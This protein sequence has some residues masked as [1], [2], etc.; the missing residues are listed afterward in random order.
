MKDPYLV[1]L[2]IGIGVIFIS[3]IAVYYSH[4]KNSSIRI[5]N[6]R[7]PQKY[8]LPEIKELN[9]Q[10]TCPL[11][12]CIIPPIVFS[13][14]A[15]YENKSYDRALK[16][17]IDF[18]K[19]NP[20]KAENI[21]NSYIN[22]TTKYQIY[23]SKCDEIFKNY[24]KSIGWKYSSDPIPRYL[25][26]NRKDWKKAQKIVSYFKD[27]IIRIPPAFSCKILCSY[28]S[29]A[30]RVSL[31]RYVEFTF[32]QFK[33]HYDDVVSCLKS[34]RNSEVNHNKYYESYSN[35]R[36][37]NNVNSDF[38]YNGNDKFSTNKSGYK[39][40]L[41]KQNKNENNNSNED[42][43]NKIKA[44][45]DMAMSQNVDNLK[46]ILELK[47]KISQLEYENKK[48]KEQYVENNQ[49]K[50]KTNVN[51]I[52]YSQ[53]EKPKDPVVHNEKQEKITS[54]I[55]PFEN[56]K[57]IQDKKQEK[58]NIK[59]LQKGEYDSQFIKCILPE[60]VTATSAIVKIQITQQSTDLEST[61][62]SIYAVS[63]IGELCSNIA[64]IKT[65]KEKEIIDCT[66]RIQAE[67]N[68]TLRLVLSYSKAID[69]VLME[70]PLYN[71]SKFKPLI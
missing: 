64:T 25:F 14:R 66:L 65:E 57:S 15:Q 43:L 44:Q 31:S 40:D 63:Q 19:S 29:P 48:I 59:Q 4:N 60:S 33:N 3:A 35:N 27:T 34:K 8:V 6:L 7:I 2:V 62:Y 21:I 47:N 58:K 20:Y 32:E 42:S 46:E 13:T 12:Q 9:K 17:L 26:N 28:T 38:R 16:S 49:N 18:I 52:Q 61:E 55:K 71:K 1:I 69:N 41:N 5:N 56:N 45:R 39:E 67:P 30:G 11:V 68:T 36:T 54:D 10:Y 70:V 22:A 37:Q 50:L 24:C 23:L 51:N 53:S